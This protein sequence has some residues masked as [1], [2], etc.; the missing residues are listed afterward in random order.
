MQKLNLLIEKYSHWQPLEDYIRR[1][2]ALSESDFSSCVEN[3]KAILESV[4]KEICQKRGQTIGKNDSVAKVMKTAF[5]SFGYPKNGT[6]PQIAGAISNI[7]QQM[8]N[9]RNDIGMT[10][11]GKTMGEL[12]TRNQAISQLSLDFL[13]H[14]TEIVACFLI[15]LFETEFPKKVEMQEVELK[16]EDEPD[17]NE[18][19][20][21]TFGDFGMGD[22]SFTASEILF[23]CDQQA[24]EEELKIFKENMV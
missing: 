12:E 22:Y 24:Y 1:I 6:F 9:L 13:L 15:E 5:D 20:D 17:F 19:W 11:H 8:G 2:E 18:V 3:A 23:N 21:E 7:G 14:S 16:Y 10:A 4:S